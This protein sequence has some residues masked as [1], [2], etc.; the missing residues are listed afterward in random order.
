M[1]QSDFKPPASEP[2]PKHRHRLPLRHRHYGH[3]W[4]HPH[5]E[6]PKTSTGRLA[7]IRTIV[8]LIKPY[9]RIAFAAWFGTCFRSAIL[10]LIPVFSKYAIDDGIQKDSVAVLV[11]FCAASA[12]II[13]IAAV[14]S[15]VRW[16]YGYM[17]ADR[18]TTSLQAQTFAHMETL[19][20]RQIEEIGAGTL[21]SRVCND[22][23]AIRILLQQGLVTVLRNG[24]SAVASLIFMVFI[25]WELTLL[26]LTIMPLLFLAIWLY[27][28]AARPV[29]AKTRKTL[30]E[31]TTS[32][33]DSF[34]IMQIVHAY[35]QEDNQ[36][37]KFNRA[38]LANRQSQLGPN[39]YSSLFGPALS[40]ITALAIGALIIY[41]G[42]QASGGHIQIGT[43]VAFVGLTGTF[44]AGIVGLSGTVGTYES[45]MAALDQVFDFLAIE[46][47]LDE[48]E[49]PVA[50]PAGHHAFRFEDVSFTDKHVTDPDLEHLTFKIEPGGRTAIV[51]EIG[52]GRSIICRL[53]ARVS[54]PDSGR[55][56][57]GGIDIQDLDLREYHR[58][59]RYVAAVPYIFASTLRENLLAGKPDATDEE[60]LAIMEVV[61][62]PGF[63]A[64]FS[65]GLD[66]AVTVA[67]RNLSSGQV[68]AVGVAR[69]IINFPDVIIIDGTLDRFDPVA[70]AKLS[71]R[72][73]EFSGQRTAIIATERKSIA[74]RSRDIMMIDQ[75]KIIE[76][77]TYDE[78]LE[79]GGPF[80]K[81]EHSLHFP[82]IWRAAS[83]QSI[84]DPNSD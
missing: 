70:L 78:L 76:T 60:L 4:D 3:L 33:Y 29:Y 18:A 28:R 66:S 6:K 12:L 56:T 38:N 27:K 2:S 47:E 22:A 74:S 5:I 61:G 31:V 34:N 54:K 84:A 9:R 14:G 40:A 82:E 68:S 32:A 53:I 69:A 37:E 51:G 41:G 25:D 45:G 10:I 44:F 75:G 23:P 17:L 48:P 26:T 62:G 7:E 79:A 1:T 67:G 8:H 15:A 13:V 80:S 52:S 24:V 20:Q 50:V 83:P 81:H 46:T 36:K 72:M 42:L 43:I 16:D 57:Y 65:N 77:G 59:V 71:D 35:G 30:A 64:S 19:S 63:I 39:I 21:I 49:T 58:R 11:G 73:R 55:I